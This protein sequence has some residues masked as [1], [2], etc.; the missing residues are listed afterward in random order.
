MSRK[1]GLS[2]VFSHEGP[3][4]QADAPRQFDPLGRRHGKNVA[5]VFQILKAT[6]SESD[7]A[8]G[9]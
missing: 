3:A 2:N 6:D 7:G 8:S 5:P 1:S 9:H 4:V